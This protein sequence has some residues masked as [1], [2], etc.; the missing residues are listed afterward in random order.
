MP[1]EGFEGFERA[2]PPPGFD[3]DFPRDSQSSDSA[4]ASSITDTPIVSPDPTHTFDMMM[5]ER[6]DATPTAVTDTVGTPRRSGKRPVSIYSTVGIPTCPELGAAERQQ[7]PSSRNCRRSPS[8]P[9]PELLTSAWIVPAAALADAAARDCAVVRATIAVEQNEGLGMHI[10]SDVDRPGVRLRLV[11]RAGPLGQTGKFL[12]GDE[13]IAINGIDLV[14]AE[15]DRVVE[16]VMRVEN[17]LDLTIARAKS[18]ADA[19]DAVG[20]AVGP[21]APERLRSESMPLLSKSASP[22]GAGPMQTPPPRQRPRV[23]SGGSAVSPHER[24]FGSAEKL[25]WFFGRNPDRMLRGS[26]SIPELASTRPAPRQGGLN[27]GGGRHL[28]PLRPPGTP[29]PTR[30]PTPKPPVEASTPV[31]RMTPAVLAELVATFDT[32]ASL[33]I[34]R[35][36]PAHR[37]RPPSGDASLNHRFSYAVTLTNKQHWGNFKH[38]GSF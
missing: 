17:V 25:R 16:V 23:S 4:C 27:L 33:V 38:L 12:P 8:R 14:G 6:A 7:Q 34:H 31:R 26:L 10:Y 30:A 29:L 18:L 15:H 21:P 5:E 19:P 11:E 2:A 32:E 28:P 36:L 13:I 37:G 1:F 20:P 35:R 24:P 22:E 3:A 9:R